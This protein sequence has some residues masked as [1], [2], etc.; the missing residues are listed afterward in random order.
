M[1]QGCCRLRRDLPLQD[2]ISV[3]NAIHADPRI[4]ECAA[5]AVPDRRLGELVTAV[6]VPKHDY[7]GKIKEAEVIE[8]T[9]QQCVFRIACL[10]SWRPS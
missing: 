6:V 9:K 4:L 3:E 2:S 5:V 8:I 1:S 7:R 10:V